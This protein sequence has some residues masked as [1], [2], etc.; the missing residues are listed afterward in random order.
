MPHNKS[1]ILIITIII[2]SGCAVSETPGTPSILLEPSPVKILISEV[3]TGTEDN[4]QADFIELYNSGTQIADLKGYS[5]WYQLKDGSEEILIYRWEQNTLIPPL[6]FYALVQDG[7]DFQVT[8]DLIINQ[9]LVPNRGSL[10]LR[11]AEV[12]EDQLAWGKGPSSNAEGSPADPMIPGSSLTRDLSP[13][14]QKQIDTDD[15]QVDFQLNNTPGLKNSSTLNH[16]RS[17]DLGLSIM[18]P[19]TIKPGDDFQI[20]VRILNQTGI[21]LEGLQVSLPLPEH[22]IVMEESD[23]FSVIDGRLI[24]EIPDLEDGLV[25][26]ET[27]PFQAELTFADYT[28]RDSFLKVE[29]WPLPAFYGPI[30]GEI[31]GGPIPVSTARELVGKE[32]VVEGIS[33]MYV[34]GFYAGSGAKFYLED[35]TGGIQV[36]V[37]GAGNS[38]VVPLGSTVQVKGK[39]EIYRDSIELIPSSEDLVSIIKS[40]GESEE[41]TPQPI[42]IE[43]IAAQGELVAGNL[44]EVEGQIARIEEFSYSY[45]IDLFDDNGNK[46]SLYIDKNTGITLDDIE[47]D[48]FYSATGIMELFDGNLQLY[49]RLQSDLQRIYEPGL[50]IRVT[51]PTTARP[52]E[53][54]DVVYTITNHALDPDQNLIISVRTDPQLE[55]IEMMDQGRMN[56]R[57]IVWDLDRIDGDG[58]EIS[59]AYKAQLSGDADYVMFDD[60]RV[61]SSSWPESAYGIPSYTFSGITVP[62]WAIQGTGPRTSFNLAKLTT[63]GT[64]IGIFPDLE[65]FWIQENESD[66]D[67]VTSPGLFVR[68]GPNLPDLSP[69]DVVQVTGRVRESFQQT[70]LEVISQA[71][72]EVIGSSRLPEPIKLDPPLNNN[73]SQVYYESLEGALVSVPG[74]AVVVGPTT[75]YGEFAVVI[76]D[77]GITRS[78]Q[79]QDHGMLIHI[80]DGSSFTHETRDTL[81][82]AVSVGD[83]VFGV[84]GPLAFTYGNY[85]IEP[86]NQYQVQNKKVQVPSLPPLDEGSFSIMTWNVENLFDFVV[87]HPSSPPL[88]R[89]SEYKQDITKVAKTIDAAGF[90]TIIGFQEVENLEILEDVALEPILSDYQYQAVLIEGT[91]SRGIDVGYL[92]RGDQAEIL[93]RDQFLAPGNITSRPP[94]MIEVKI[95]DSNQH[96]FV[97]NNHFTSMSGGEKATEPRRNAQAAWNVEIARNI[98]TQNLLALIAIIGDLNSYYDSPPINTIEEAGFINTFDLLEAQERYT[99]VYQGNSQVLDHILINDFLEAYLIDVQVLHSNADYTLPSSDDQSIIHKSDHDPVIARFTIP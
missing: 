9:S 60:F 67:P 37:S 16:P 93:N 43:E 99:Y 13:D 54:F 4:N 24:L 18:L 30:Y 23:D 20:E 96:L 46:L 42:T 92:V 34:G 55:V 73:D 49:P 41:K 50:A 75:R 98:E 86:T 45:E 94:L 70:E 63:Q 77:L 65:G 72:I 74:S 95:G 68:T 29:N 90:P 8:P 22:F 25:L 61:I 48:L 35:E 38:L 80:D 56:N 57:T 85:K 84:R 87:P 66:D 15:N 79:D 83:Q 1:I 82:S 88:P 6:G 78:W 39:I 27:I 76:A 5:L 21:L 62:I 89:V 91:D 19:E 81:A 53:P 12:V 59:V 10:V 2:I 44:L 58:S 17:Q 69:G 3:L 11:K 33:T 40:P 31:G 28:I 51:A 14:N 47:S 97:L 71:N 36:Y 7:Q 26:N 32:V 64:V 52:G